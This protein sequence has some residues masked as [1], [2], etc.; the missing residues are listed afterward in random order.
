MKIHFLKTM[1]SDIILLEY[2]GKFAFV[3]TGFDEQ[4]DQI[5]DYLDNLGVTQ[6]EFILLTHFHRDHYGNI[7]NLI[8]DYPVKTVYFKEYGGHDR[9]TAW[10]SLA[11]DDY[12]LSEKVKWNDIKNSIEKYSTLRMVEEL[13]S[14]RYEDIDIMLYST[15][16]NVE[17]IW[18]DESNKTTY[19]KNILSEN[20]NSLAVFF[21]VNGKTVF[22]GGDTMDHEEKHP[23][24]NFVNLQIAKQINR[25]I[26]LY[27][28]PHHGTN[29]TACDETLSIYKPQ[30]AVITNGMEYLKDFDSISSLKRANPEVE[31]LLTEKEDVVIHLPSKE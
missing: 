3:D 13:K 12:R 27:K 18:N 30:V 25:P 28:A 5:R 7:V 9:C 4:Y 29:H 17:F 10:G 19:H 23:L 15:A 24:V 22:L 11:D 16:N 6:I 1:W 26:Y 20:E 14:V 8:K 31:I 21:E 2:K